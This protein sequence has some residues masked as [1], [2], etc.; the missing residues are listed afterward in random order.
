MIVRLT[1]APGVKFPDVPVMGR[2]VFPVT[3]ILSA[4]EAEAAVYVPPR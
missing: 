4:P 2:F 3:V 1:L